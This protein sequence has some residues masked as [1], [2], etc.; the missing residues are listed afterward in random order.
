M[1]LKAV[2]LLRETGLF[3]RDEI[4]EFDLYNEYKRGCPRLRSSSWIHSLSTLVLLA[5]K[6]YS[7]SPISKSP[8]AR[9]KAPSNPSYSSQIMDLIPPTR[10]S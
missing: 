7:L 6:I 8:H 1:I 10:D 2:S 5:D 9:D 4:E 3:N